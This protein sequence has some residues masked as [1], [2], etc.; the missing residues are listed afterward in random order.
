VS[1][2]VIHAAVGRDAFC[3]VNLRLKCLATGSSRFLSPL[4]TCR[5]C[6]RDL[7]R[8]KLNDWTISV[9]EGFRA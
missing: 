9:G 1:L 8:A 7:A 6:R 5:A 4:V 3:A 2:K